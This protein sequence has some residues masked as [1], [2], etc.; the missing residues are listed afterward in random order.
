MTGTRLAVKLPHAVLN[1]MFICNILPN[2]LAIIIL[3]VLKK[4]RI[5][6]SIQEKKDR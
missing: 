1:E 2:M 3:H 4:I 5:I 6:L